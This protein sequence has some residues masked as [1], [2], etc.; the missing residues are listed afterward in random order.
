MNADGLPEYAAFACRPDA[1]QRIT[2]AL[3]A[4][5]AILASD[6]I[7]THKRELLGVCL[8]QLSQ[9]EGRSKYSTR[10]MSL[11]AIHRPTNALAHE[12]VHE[13]AKLIRS[14]MSG[15][16]SIEMIS[17]FA[18]ACIVTREEHARLNVICRANPSLHGWD[19]YR[20]ASIPVIDR[21][22]NCWLIPP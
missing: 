3:A 9:A 7:P 10:F 2:S 5:R 11:A 22:L 16:L 19:R 18:I 1:G 12:H 13:R 4:A 6:A 15:E 21:A 14:L 8:W 20:A 17:R